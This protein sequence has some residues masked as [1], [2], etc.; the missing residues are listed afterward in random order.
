MYCNQTS[1]AQRPP[2]LQEYRGASVQEGWGEDSEDA[3]ME[4]ERFGSSG[5]LQDL[6]HKHRYTF[7]AVVPNLSS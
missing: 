1:G 6:M 2:S 4:K 3:E 5:K 7:W